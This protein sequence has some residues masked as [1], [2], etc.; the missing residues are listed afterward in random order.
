MDRHRC[1]G[2][3]AELTVNTLFSLISTV[4]VVS[5]ESCTFVS[6]GEQASVICVD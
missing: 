1:F 5:T 4:A 3:L 6:C 2:V